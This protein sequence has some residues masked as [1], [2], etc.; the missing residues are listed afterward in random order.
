MM[1]E[2]ERLED[3]LGA[4]DAVT[5]VLE[6]LD[7]LLQIIPEIQPMIGFDHKHPH[8][9]LDVWEHTLCALNLAPNNFDVRLAL[10]LHDI[11]KPHSFQEGQDVRHFRGHP[12]VS[13]EIAKGILSRLGYEEEYID[14]ICD[15][16]KRHDTPLSESDIISDIELSKTIFEVQKCDAMAHNPKFNQKRLEYIKRTN[17]LFEKHSERVEVFRLCRKDEAL[18][19]LN[20][21]SLN[22]VGSYCGNSERNT[23]DYDESI[24]YLHF[25]KNKSDLLYLNT[26]KERYICTYSIPEFVLRNYFGHGWYRSYINFATLNN[27]EE[28]AIPSTKVKFEYLQSIDEITEDIDVDEMIEDESLVEYTQRIFE[29]GD[30]ENEKSN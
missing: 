13:A 29:S 15:I 8:H 20:S 14:F 2:S 7:E 22:N 1:S 16:V 5:C 12:I 11:G 25:F 18:E 24:K 30:F 9:H 4:E 23:H 3:I 17:E 27:V 28:Y 26:L 6:H 10:L 21:Q 19:I